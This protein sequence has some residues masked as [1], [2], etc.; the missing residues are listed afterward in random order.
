MPA[1]TNPQQDGLRIAIVGAGITGVNLALGLQA[2]HISFTIYERAPSFREIGAGIGF[3][4]NAERAMG[5]L[6]P[7]VV[8]AYKRVANPNGEDFFQWVDGFATD[9]LMYKLHVGK[10][11]FQGGRRSDILD[12]WAKLVPSESVKFSK[13][14][15]TVQDEDDGS[16]TIRF[17]DGASTNADVLIGCDGIRSRIRQLI[18]PSS[19]A[20]AIPHYSS[21]F[22]YRALVPM[23]P[24]VAA[25]GPH[26]AG[27]RFMYNGPDAHLITYPVG[28]NSVLNILVVLSDTQPW[29][30]PH[31][32]TAPGSKKE[33][34]D[35]FAG[36]CPT[37]RRIVDLLPEEMDKWAIFDMA[38]HPASTYVKG[39]MC[40][41]GDAAHATGPH[42]GAGGG[43]GVEDALVLAAVLEA[44]ANDM[45]AG[46]GEKEKLRKS[47][48]VEAALRAYNNVRY[49][50]TQ[51]VVRA[52][53]DA[54]DLFQWQDGEVGSDAEKFGREITWRFKDI[55]EY[56]VEG[57]V[58]E[59]VA[60]SRGSDKKAIIN[61]QADWR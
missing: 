44:V 53:R 57:M 26:R 48:M 51:A 60:K 15:N 59:A 24:A 54:V 1:A 56:D 49:E 50:R 11:G 19:P 47:E 3:S 45:A 35:A 39:R 2:R 12:E 21:K 10:D 7:A 32:H 42:L 38:E 30:D 52:T 58:K 36:W 31:K 40:V 16:L 61:G 43:M 41:A 9:E 6:N 18:L 27:T 5:L 13:E 4:P 25:L 20:A 28:G 37:V 34:V 23:P 33:V 22:C 17:K 46:S 29:P 55:W 14:V 8:A